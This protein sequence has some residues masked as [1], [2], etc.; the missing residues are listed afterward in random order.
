MIGRNKFEASNIEG[1]EVPG[2]HPDLDLYKEVSWA[3]GTSRPRMPSLSTIPIDKSYYKVIPHQFFGNITPNQ[4]IFTNLGLV[5][6]GNSITFQMVPKSSQTDETQNFGLNK[7]HRNKTTNW[8]TNGSSNLLMFSCL[9]DSVKYFSS[10]AR[11]IASNL[12]Y[13]LSRLNSKSYREIGG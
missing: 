1:A 6:K 13:F 7:S 5:E 2:C 3:G 11:L 8:I 10:K 4:P 12:Y 9:E